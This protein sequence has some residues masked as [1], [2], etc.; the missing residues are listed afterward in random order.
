[1]FNETT[2]YLVYFW[3]HL[4]ILRSKKQSVVLCQTHS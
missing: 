3:T 2:S 1:M 4:H